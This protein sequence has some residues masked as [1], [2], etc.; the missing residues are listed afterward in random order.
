LQKQYKNSLEKDKGLDIEIENLRMHNQILK[1]ILKHEIVFKSFS[2]F[3]VP[4]ETR[5]RITKFKVKRGERINP[6]RQEI[7]SD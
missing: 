5:E 4:V 2:W 3:I 1:E 7:Q 6:I